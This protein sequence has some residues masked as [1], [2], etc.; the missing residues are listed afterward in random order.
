MKIASTIPGRERPDGGFTLIEVLVVITIIGVLIALLLPAVQAA[1][2]AARRMQC[3]NNLRQMGLALQGYHGVSGCFPPGRMS[4]HL[5][6]SSR[7][8]G[9]CWQ[10]NIAVHVHLAPFLE[11]ASMF[12]AF[13][14]AASRADPPDCAQNLT[15]AS[16]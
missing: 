3:S 4:P 12:H 6:N 14:F 13:N 15:V 5:G 7:G 16:L 2:E 11:A 10:G 8:A 1:R 9:A